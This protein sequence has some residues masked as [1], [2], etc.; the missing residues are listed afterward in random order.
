[1]V[2]KKAG[3]VLTITPSPPFEKRPGWMQRKTLNWA[4]SRTL[5]FVNGLI[6]SWGGRLRNVRRGGRHRPR[7]RVR[8]W[9]AYG[10]L[11]LA[12]RLVLVSG[13]HA[14]VS[15]FCAGQ[16]QLDLV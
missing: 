12:A 6:S 11:A 3:R 9:R 5:I 4:I 16:G 13:R 2:G 8:Q 14:I 1:M 15:G 10:G 7:V